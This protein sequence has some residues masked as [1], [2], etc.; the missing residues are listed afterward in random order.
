MLLDVFISCKRVFLVMELAARG[1]LKDIFH[2][3]TPQNNKVLLTESQA[4]FYFRE[5]SYAVKAM[6]D[7]KIAHR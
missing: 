6:H 4:R 2:S 3:A 5:I 7:K 1:S